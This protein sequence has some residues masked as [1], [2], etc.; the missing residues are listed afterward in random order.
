MREAFQRV[1]LRA[2]PYGFGERLVALFRARDAAADLR[3]KPCIPPA[4]TDREVFAK[5]PLDDCWWDAGLPS[6]FFYLWRNER[7]KVPP[8]WESTMRDFHEELRKDT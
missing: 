4:D 5:L 6:L 1:R 3:G 7:L 8:S 2:Y